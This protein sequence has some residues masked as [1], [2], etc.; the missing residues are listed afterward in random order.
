LEVEQFYA[1]RLSDSMSSA[2]VIVDN[3]AAECVAIVKKLLAFAHL[4]TN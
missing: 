3:A 4:F 1:C 2:N